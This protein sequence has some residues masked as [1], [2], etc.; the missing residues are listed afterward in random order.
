MTNE[1][2]I[3]NEIIPAVETTTEAVSMQ[4]MPQQDSVPVVE[5]PVFELPDFPIPTDADAP[6]AVVARTPEEIDAWKKQRDGRINACIR[7]GQK[8]YI[9]SFVS[10]KNKRAI[11]VGKSSN[12]KDAVISEILDFG[13]SGMGQA[14]QAVCSVGKS[15]TW[16]YSQMKAERYSLDKDTLLI[17]GTN[18]NAAAIYIQKALFSGQINFSKSCSLS[19]NDRQYVARSSLKIAELIRGIKEK[20]GCEVAVEALDRNTITSNGHGASDLYALSESIATF[21]DVD[22][23]GTRYQMASVPVTLDNGTKRSFNFFTK[24]RPTFQGAKGVIRSYKAKNGNTPAEFYVESPYRG[25]MW[26]L[27]N[28]VKGKINN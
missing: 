28:E 15:I 26:N 10:G 1:N 18:N 20:F 23:K 21:G 9:C 7:A 4:E 3:N 25:T 11:A 22:I 12:D 19:Q 13:N 5:A 27:Y 6:A 2:I 14:A 17:L 8:L 24:F 16:L